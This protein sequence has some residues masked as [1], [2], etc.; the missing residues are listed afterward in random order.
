MV[1]HYLNCDAGLAPESIATT[2]RGVLLVEHTADCPS[3]RAIMS[4]GYLADEIGAF[5]ATL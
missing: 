1:A 3:F 5:T 2:I 4:N